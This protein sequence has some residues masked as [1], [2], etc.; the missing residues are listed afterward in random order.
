MEAKN[1][2]IRLQYEL[3]KRV[4]NDSEFLEFVNML[5]EKP[6]IEKFFDP[7]RYK[8]TKRQERNKRFYEKNKE[9]HWNYQQKSEKSCLPLEQK[10]NN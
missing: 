8:R 6:N 4:R 2:L 9:K 1:V 3:Q 7:E 10:E 5:L